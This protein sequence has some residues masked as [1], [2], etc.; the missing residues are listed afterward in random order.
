MSHIKKAEGIFV[1]SAKQNYMRL[2]LSELTSSLLLYPNNT[3]T[4]LLRCEVHL[5]KYSHSFIAPSFLSFNMHFSNLGMHKEAL[6]DASAAF[7][8]DPYCGQA[9][10]L[11]GQS[12]HSLGSYYNAVD[13][14]VIAEQLF[15]QGRDDMLDSLRFVIL[16]AD[17]LFSG[18]L[19]AK[20]KDACE[21]AY[22]ELDNKVKQELKQLQ[23]YLLHNLA[24]SIP[25]T[26]S[27]D[28]G[29]I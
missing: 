21:T 20:A 9:A 22:R 29:E 12:Y 1:I 8:R 5:Y 28:E 6:V 3:R 4:I 27:V 17:K 14:F 19:K 15:A 26:W 18:Q 24:F 11:L 16:T 7:L 23:Q 13:A 2:A 25:E 10:F